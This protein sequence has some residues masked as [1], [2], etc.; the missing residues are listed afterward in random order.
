MKKQNIEPLVIQRAT[1]NRL[2]LYYCYLKDKA[3]KDNIEFIS[4]TTIA[5]SLHLNSIQVRKDMAF[6]SQT[7]G[8]PRKGFEIKSLINDIENY[9][10]Y[11]NV[12]EA[13]IVG[14]GRLGH[15]LLAYNGFQ[16]YGLHIVAGFDNDSDLVGIKVSDHPIF[17]MDKLYSIINRLQ[18]NIGI[19]TVPAEH[20]QE[21]CNMMVKAGI[22]A[23]W[24]FA[25]IHLE[26]PEG[27]LVQYENLAVSLAKLSKELL[28][29]LQN[30]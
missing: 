11:N 14:I 7:A 13:I 18:I 10:G 9:L 26:V 17:P 2:P 4:S 29:S 8:K 30:K 5:N 23:I 22:K 27:I 19:I 3:E 15:T 6:V 28:I 16:N 1:L 12:N 21:I 25:P 20:A 24:N